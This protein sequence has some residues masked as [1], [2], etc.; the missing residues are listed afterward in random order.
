MIEKS[1]KIVLFLPH[2][3]RELGRDEIVELI[4]AYAQAARR[5]KVA[6]LKR[7]VADLLEFIR[8]A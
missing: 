4:D 1:N 5:A 2:P 6:E 7:E 8:K 3:A